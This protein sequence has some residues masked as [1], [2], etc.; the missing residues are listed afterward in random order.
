VVRHLS[1]EIQSVMQQITL[2]D[3]AT[4]KMDVSLNG[5]MNAEE[6]KAE[7]NLERELK[8]PSNLHK[9]SDLQEQIRSV[10]LA[11]PID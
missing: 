1:F 2:S 11:L 10:Q 5:E 3:V 9:K 6:L 8:T 7:Q 4:M